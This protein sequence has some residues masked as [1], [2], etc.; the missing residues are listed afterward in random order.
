MGNLCKAFGALVK[1]YSLTPEDSLNLR[2]A[3]Q[4]K[5]V[6]KDILFGG[7]KETDIPNAVK[8]AFSDLPYANDRQREQKEMDAVKQLTR[9]ARSE[10]RKAYRPATKGINAS[11]YPHAVFYSKTPDGSLIIEGVI[12]HFSKPTISQKKADN[13]DR[14]AIELYQLLQYLRAFNAMRQKGRTVPERVYLKA[15][16]Y[17]MRFATDRLNPYHFD[18]D[19]FNANK[20]ANIVSILEERYGVMPV[21]YKLQ[22]TR[23]GLKALALANYDALYKDALQMEKTGIEKD[24]CTDKECDACPIKAACKFV[25]PPRAIK[26]SPVQRS[27]RSM[28]LSRDQQRAVD[29]EKGVWRINA[30]AGTGKTL[31]ITMRLVA[32][33]NKGV[34]PEEILMI[35]FTNAAA[36][37]MRE[38]AKLY[39]EEIGEVEDI[40]GLRITTYNAFGD[41]ILKANYDKL[42]FTSEPKVIDEVERF[43]VIADL[44]KDHPVASLDYRNFTMNTGTYKGA[45]PIVA[46]IFEI[47]KA[48]GWYLDTDAPAIQKKLTEQQYYVAQKTVEEVIPLYNAYD[49]K[50]RE[51]NLIEFSDQEQMVFELLYKDPYLLEEYGIRHII[52]DECQDNSERQIEFLK[53][54]KDTPAFESLMVVGDDSQAIYGFR[55]TSPE[56]LIN[57]SKY[58]EDNVNDIFLLENHRSQEKIIDFANKIN[59]MNVNKVS[60]SL[61]ATRPA[62]K[63]VVVKGFCSK[64][65]EYEYVINGI[66]D[67]LANGFKHE[68]IAVICYSKPELLKMADLLDAENIPCVMMNPELLIDNS[69]VQAAISMA[70]VMQNTGDTTNLLIYANALYGGGLCDQPVSVIQAKT[71]EALAGILEC[72]KIAN[73]VERREKIIEMAKALDDVEDEVYEGFID[74]L[75]F[76]PTPQAIFE[77]ANDFNSFGQETAIR[78]NHTYPGVVLV[79]AHSSK[80][81]EWP[82]V[83]NMITKYDAENVVGIEKVEERRRLL[84]VSATRARDE[85]YITSQWK[86]YTKVDKLNPKR[87]EEIYNNYLIDAFKAVGTA[88]TNESIGAAFADYKAKKKK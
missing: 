73:P 29:V 16:V 40:S 80:G 5:T 9:Y 37:E 68:D 64:D 8:T 67:H 81:L 28:V 76:K 4:K 15:S 50:L 10:K 46:K 7:L 74:S 19:F 62:G 1:K 83:Y 25:N 49:E 32:L 54:L 3:V 42:G 17:Y 66:K 55:K 71:G 20:A 24:D 11:R 59:D 39:N 48:E 85:L 84:F 75:N 6:L 78:R 38:R 51:L 82:V 41:A 13:G 69:R 72:N 88:V 77:Y 21:L 61:I 12:Y 30:G 87:R 60:K 57:F 70:K 18:T 56:Y 47:Q 63:D 79:T 53:V 45:L 44:M 52:V 34:K 22:S 23:T 27:V 26:A 86:S 35:T 58:I 33:M 31:T 43:R 36:E 2:E 14:D 65:D